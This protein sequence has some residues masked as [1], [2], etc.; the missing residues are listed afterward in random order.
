MRYA[1]FSVNENG[2]LRLGASAR[3]LLPT[4][5]WA[6]RLSPI[7]T[8]YGADQRTHAGDGKVHYKVTGLLLT[9]RSLLNG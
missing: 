2:V 9:E 6:R 4:S 7:I 8:A 5:L 3:L 1:Q